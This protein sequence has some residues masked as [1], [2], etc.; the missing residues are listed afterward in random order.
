MVEIVKRTYG[1][2]FPTF[3]GKRLIEFAKQRTIKA[4]RPPCDIYRIEI[5]RCN[6]WSKFPL[7]ARPDDP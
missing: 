1:G 4:L 6:E 7:W 3:R 5:R 2:V